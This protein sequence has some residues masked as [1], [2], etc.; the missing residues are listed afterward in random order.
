MTKSK[1]RVWL[2]ISIVLVVTVI[3]V[4]AIKK[5]NNSNSIKVA[6]EFV[7]LRKIVETVSANGKI[8]PAK[9]IKIS[10]YISGEVVEL[11]VKEGEFVK[12]GY[13]LA[14][15]DPEIYLRAYEKTEASLNTSQANQANSKARLSQSKAQFVKSELD[16]KRSKTLWEKKVISDSDFET[17]K[18]NYDVSKADVAAA[19]ESYRSSQFQ[20]SSAKASLKESK[21]NLNRTTIYAPNDGTVSKLSVDVGERVTGASTFS[22]GTEIMRIA[23][24]EVLEVNVEVNENDIVR[25]NLLDTAI[26]EVDAYLNRDFK[27]LVT[28]IATSANTIGVSADQVTNFDV[29][30]KMLKTSYE[31]LIKSDAAISSPFRPGMSATVEI[32]TETAV[33]IK[34]I[35]IQA[36]TTRADTSGRMKTAKEKREEERLSSEKGIGSSTDKIEEYVFVY[37]EGKA[38]LRKVK[39]GIQ[40]NKYI[41]VTEGLK[42]GDEIIV[43][44]YRA[45]SKTLKNNDNVEIVKKDEL[46]KSDKDN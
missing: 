44:P 42:D 28:E 25:V 12:K 10:P 4:L 3:T 33:N 41:E 32:E 27:G 43:A 6:T 18:S 46:F 23:D 22:A 37:E 31:D 20:V 14:R 9:D 5:G 16:F 17:A 39:T 11:Y 1:K 15:I 36:V 24:L 40:D 30:I 45:V 34:T 7:E 38:K 29:K 19:E 26:I 8:Q 21:E 13:K 35:A 2:I